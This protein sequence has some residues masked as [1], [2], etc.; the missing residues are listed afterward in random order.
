[1]LNIESMYENIVLITDDNYTTDRWNIIKNLFDTIDITVLDFEMRITEKNNI[2]ESYVDIQP[3]N[4]NEDLLLATLEQ[5]KEFEQESDEQLE[6]QIKMLAL[7][8]K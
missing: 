8:R 3:N 5:F 7:I 4:I 2:L 6:L 1:M